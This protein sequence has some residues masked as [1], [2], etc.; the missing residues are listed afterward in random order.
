M[1]Q[2][3]IKNYQRH[4]LYKDHYFDVSQDDLISLL[5]YSWSI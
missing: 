1:M 5:C 4:I 2:M 3:G